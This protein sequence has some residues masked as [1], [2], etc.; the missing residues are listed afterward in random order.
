MVEL[1]E[2]D[3]IEQH[4]ELVGAFE[5]LRGAGARIAADDAGSGYAGLAHILRLR[6]E[7]LKLDSA[8]VCGIASDVGRQAM[9]EAMVGFTRRTGATLV[10]EGVETADDLATLRELD[11]PLAQGYLLG[12]PE[13]PAE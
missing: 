6:P 7:V 12:R 11:V 10:A 5:R 2:H 9:C 13:L 8:L 3:D 4:P 1:T